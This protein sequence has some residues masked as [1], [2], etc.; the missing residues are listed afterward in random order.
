MFIPDLPSQ[1]D[2]PGDLPIDLSATGLIWILRD[3]SLGLHLSLF[4]NRQ[5]VLYGGLC[6]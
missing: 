3:R 2:T 4:P 6:V 1:L 5:Q